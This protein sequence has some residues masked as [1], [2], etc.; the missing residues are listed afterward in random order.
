MIAG[1]L[2]RTIRLAL[3]LTCL[4]VAPPSFATCEVSRDG[5]VAFA[6]PGFFDQLEEFFDELFESDD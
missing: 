1:R 6:A 5:L 3:L 4:G 2:A